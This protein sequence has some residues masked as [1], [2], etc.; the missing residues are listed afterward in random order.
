MYLL[1]YINEIYSYYRKVERDLNVL[2]PETKE[3]E[4]KAYGKLREIL[5]DWLVKVHSSFQLLPETLYLAVNLIDRFLQKKLVT[6][7]KL[8][9]VGVTAL[10]IACKYEQC[11]YPEIGEFAQQI[12]GKCSKDDIIIIELVILQTL[13]F[14]LTVP[15]IFWFLIRFCKGIGCNEKT[16]NLANYIAEKTLLKLN[17]GKFNPSLIAASSIYLARKYSFSEPFW[18]HE[19]ADYSGYRKLDMIGCINELERL[20]TRARKSRYKAVYNKYCTLEY[21]EVAKAI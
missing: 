21:G 1:V 6:R 16:I 17:L 15:S 14:N 19:L 2:S 11:L 4:M 18:P 20:M 7:D 12:N 13:N 3:L 8:Q 10:F 5:I 9:L